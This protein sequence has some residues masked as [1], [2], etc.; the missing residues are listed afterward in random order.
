VLIVSTTLTIAVSAAIYIRFFARQSASRDRR[1]L[2]FSESA[3][4]IAAVTT[5]AVAASGAN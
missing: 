4:G 1:H 2:R 5:K 3:A